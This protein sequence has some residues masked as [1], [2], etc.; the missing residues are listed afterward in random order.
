MNRTVKN[1]MWKYA[2][3]LRLSRFLKSIVISASLQWATNEKLGQNEVTCSIA[4]NN[5]IHNETTSVVCVSTMVFVFCP[6]AVY[7]FSSS[8]ICSPE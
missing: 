3:S 4:D 6:K 8:P 1:C 5:L 7:I 2:L